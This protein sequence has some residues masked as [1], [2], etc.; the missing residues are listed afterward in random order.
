MRR[1]W[2]GDVLAK[3]FLVPWIGIGH[4]RYLAPYLPERAGLPIIL[5][6]GN[7]GF[8]YSGA[9]PSNIRS[10]GWDGMDSLWATVIHGFIK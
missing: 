5:Y 9:I 8:F 7:A 2:D 3:P 6:D 4:G 10:L 1:A